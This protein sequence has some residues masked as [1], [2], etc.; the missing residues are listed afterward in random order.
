MML[1]RVVE[2]LYWMA[3]YLE[4]AE[5][6]ARLVSAYSHFILDVPVGVEPGWGVLIRTIDVEPEFAARFKR[7]SERNVIKYLL[8]DTE[9]RSSIRSSIAAARENVRTTRDVLPVQTW[10]LMNELYLYVDDAASLAIARNTRFKLLEAV[11]AGNQRI[12][13]TILTTVTQDH[14]L[15]FLTLGQ[16]LERFD[17]TSRILDVGASAISR[18]SQLPAHYRLLLWGN[19]LTSLS[20]TSAYRRTM[21]PVLGRDQ[22]IDFVVKAHLFPRSLLSCLN[23]I[24]ETFGH[25]AAPAGLF[26][27]LRG[28]A[29][30]VN[31][32]S[33]EQV[34]ST[35]LH[36]AIDG[37][38]ARL[39][40]IHDAI[41][42]IWFLPVE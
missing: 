2:R 39:A 18:R 24:E 16:L 23:R 19:L 9:N 20:A 11:I 30:R 36:G 29:R 27:D 7:V 8:A 32:L 38:Q 42:E 15:W 21:G 5:D 17:M 33:V 12:N 22:V 13:G 37:F 10:E 35:D 4:R 25:L 28:L 14:V 41:R 31:D 26:R 3:R 34:S 6:T 40:N 1:S